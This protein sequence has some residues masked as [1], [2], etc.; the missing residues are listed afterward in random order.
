MKLIKKIT[1]I[2]ENFSQWFIDVITNGNLIEYGPLKGTV[3]FK[4]NSYGIWEQIQYNLNKIIKKEGVR[5]VYLPLLMPKSLIQKEKEHVDGFAPELATVTKVGDKKLNEEIYIRPTSEV[6]F[7]QLFKSEINSYND[8]PKLFNQWANVVRWEKTTNPFLRTSEFLWQE[9][10]T[11]HSTEEE[12]VNFSEKMIQVYKNFYKDYLALDVVIGKKTEREKFAGA[13]TTWT[14]EAMMKDGKSLQA[15]T[16]HYL[17]QNFSKMFN[18]SFKNEN[19]QLINVYQTSWGLS[20][21]SIGAIIMAHGDNR[22]IVIPPKIAPIQVDLIEVLA[23]K[24]KNVITMANQLKKELEENGIRVRVDKSDKTIGFKAAQ[25]EIEGVPIRIEIGPRDIENQQVLIV[26]R[27][28]IYKALV[29]IDKVVIEVKKLL[30]SIHNDL[31]EKSRKLIKEN[32]IYCNSYGKFKELIKEQ[33]FVVVPIIEDSKELENKIKEETT[34]TA[35]CIPTELDLCLKEDKCIMT[36][37]LVNH[38]VLFAK[39][40]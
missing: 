22:G 28:T 34:A 24:D 39:A 31:F 13:I 7:A 3:I 25:S 23:N 16:S 29:N 17:G 1:P 36:G 30:E 15:A 40:Y 37:K 11:S 8:L 6:L 20:T 10:H 9:G 4:P 38:F 32:I 21:R 12:A 14:I 2:E 18:I 27:D 5:N 19:N 26:R 35:R 33:K